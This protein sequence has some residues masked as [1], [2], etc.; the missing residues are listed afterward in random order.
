MAERFGSAQHHVAQEVERVH[1]PRE[2]RLNEW[3]R[4][5]AGIVCAVHLFFLCFELG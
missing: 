4:E 3:T 1:D 5:F 2:D